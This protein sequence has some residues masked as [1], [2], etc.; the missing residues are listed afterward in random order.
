MRMKIST[1]KKF[2]TVQKEGVRQ[3]SREINHYSLQMIIAVG[4]KVNYDGAVQFRKWA[5]IH[6][7]HFED[8]RKKVNEYI[9]THKQHPSIKKLIYNVPITQEDYIE[10]ERIFTKELGTKEEY[11]TIYRD[12]PFGKHHLTDLLSSI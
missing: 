1:I 4:F 7:V 9:D 11:E 5:N 6:Y 12:T 3:V 8:Y 10:L 2:L